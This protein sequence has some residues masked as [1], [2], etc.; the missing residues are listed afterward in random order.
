M[1]VEV[2]SQATALIRN[3]PKTLP[4]AKQVVEFTDKIQQQASSNLADL[5]NAGPNSR[6]RC[7]INNLIYTRTSIK[8]LHTLNSK[9]SISQVVKKLTKDGYGLRNPN[10]LNP[11][12]GPNKPF[13]SI[14]FLFNGDLELPSGSESVD[15]LFIR[16]F[17][18]QQLYD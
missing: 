3:D 10:M 18:N 6:L 4:K 15:G 9:V 2:Y 5:E 14:I 12:N 1:G 7:Q 17:D 13:R 16:K 8:D 11:E